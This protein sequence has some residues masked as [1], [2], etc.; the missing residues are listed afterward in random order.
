MLA[1]ALTTAAH[2]QCYQFTANGATLR[3]DVSA[4]I[5]Q[6]GPI[7]SNG[8]SV[9]VLTFSSNNSFTSPRAS[10]SSRQSVANGDREHPVRGERRPPTSP[11]QT[12]F[13]MA[14]ANSDIN[15]PNSGE[16]TWVAYL[17]GTGDLIPSRILPPALPA[18]SV[19]TGVANSN[20]IQVTSGAAITT[21]QIDSVGACAAATGGTP[22]PSSTGLTLGDPQHLPGSCACADPINIA[23]GNLFERFADY[24]TS[25]ENPLAFTR[26]YNSLGGVNTYSTEL[27]PH[28]RS[29][30]D[31]YLHLS[32]TTVVAER[33]DG[34]QITFTLIANTWTPD[35]DLDYKLTSAAGTWTLTGPDDTVET[36]TAA[37]ASTEGLLQTIQ[38]RNGYTQTVQY[39]DNQVTAITDSF[40]RTLTFTYQNNLQNNLLH[41]VT[42]PDGLVI[43]FGYGNGQLTSSS[44][45]TAPAAIQTYLYENSAF[46]SALT[47]I[48][49]ENNNRYASW[50]YDTTGRT[51]SSQHANGA[52]LIAVNYNDTD[53]SRTVT[54]ALGQQTLYKFTT[55]QGV[56]KVTEADLLSPAAKRTFTYDT[57]GYLASRTDFNGNLTT[58]SNDAHG[59]PTTIVEASGTP[60]ART[61]TIAY[62]FAFHLPLQI[63]TPGL[64]TTFTYDNSGQMLTKTLTDIAAGATRTWAYTWSNFLE[65]AVRSPRATVTQFA[66][67]SSGALTSITNALNQITQITKRS[68]GGFP[69]TSVDPNG[70]TT[71]YTYDARQRLLSTTVATTLQL[72]T[73]TYAYDPA[74]NLLSTALPDGSSLT[75]TYDTAHRLTAVTDAL[76]NT[77]NYALDAAGD[78]T[79]TQILDP[80]G[81][82]QFKRTASF[83]TLGRTHQET[84]GANQTTTYT[85]D[86]NG[87]RLTITDP[88][89]NVAQQSFDALNRL[90]TSTDAAQGI[91]TT[92]YDAHDRR[93]SV[94]D[95]NSITTTYTYNG[96]GDLIQQSSP[97]SGIT[98]YRYDANG[99]VTQRIDARSIETDFAYDALD[100]PVSVT[101][102]AN[103]A[104]N[105][106]YRYD[107]PGHLFGIGHL[108]SV[109]DAAGTL[110][111][112]Y[113]ERGNLITDAR[114]HG[115]AALTTTY[116][117]DAASRISTVEYPSHWAVTYTRDAVGRITS[118]LAQSPFG[119]APRS[120]FSAVSYQPFG[121]A[122]AL[123]YGNGIGETR[124]FDHDYRLTRIA[125]SVQNETYL[126]DAADNLIST[127]TQ[128]FAY[129][130]LNRLTSPGYTY[131][132]D[133]NRLTE[134]SP[135][136]T[137]DGLGSLTAFTYN[138]A[139]R[140][141]TVSA[142]QQQLALYTY[143]A[144]GNRI[145]KAGNT[146]ATTLYQYDQSGHLLEEDDGQG[147]ARVLY[148]YLDD[149]PVATIQYANSQLVFLHDDR[150]NT[151]Q[152]AT[153]INKSVVWSTTYQP[154]GQIATPPTTI[155]QNLRQPGQ[156]AVPDTGLN[157]TAVHDY[158][159]ALG[160]YLAPNYIY[161]ADN[162]LRVPAPNNP[163]IFPLAARPPSVVS[164]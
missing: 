88:L 13:T 47:G 64:T 159:P 110:S 44:F 3:I 89:G 97:A 11:T 163:V 148:L 113:D 50:T 6:N 8:S 145:V 75:N 106:S 1:A 158:A 78:R 73:T 152:L 151:P 55:L 57:N 130:A 127:V 156:E 95:P 19:W 109:T 83:D 162:P 74:G 134:A 90:V 25:G 133:G 31:R 84:G 146:T 144:F 62:H 164:K 118:A 23:N 149:R 58:Y 16:H 102:P 29:N 120:L 18:F 141:A 108:T 10:T 96:F 94:T 65:T 51:L 142:G 48:V 154:F 76:G 20:Y 43:T 155:T 39:G 70:V 136:A 56:A 67:D 126:Y 81:I 77:I 161:A 35:T 122:N 7:R 112:S 45:S 129:D 86:A 71:A 92:T 34:Q 150:Q 85:Y 49:D 138:Q 61:T 24:T 160:R 124:A 147:S 33:P 9:T 132:A 137:Q 128:A 17:A 40:N 80:A 153:D 15:T 59:Q 36:Y 82:L 54:T 125:S 111:R 123:T 107:E 91:A 27:G 37:G 22:A 115:S 42:T 101:Y 12:A 100:R 60:Q 103:P 93:L 2:A 121:P 52:G 4:Q 135:A 46:A 140:L 53:G 14:V 139:N 114:I 38:T 117:Y 116:S 69:L 30:Y 68:P 41:S 21:Y 28:W 72:F 87:N 32:A 157:H 66:Y 119:G 79:Q 98:T 99:N 5:L 104:E 131:D 63:A 143:D 105:V 26:F